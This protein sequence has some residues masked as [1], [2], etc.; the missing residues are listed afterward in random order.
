MACVEAPF[1]GAGQ[2]GGVLGREGEAKPLDD[3]AEEI[4]AGDV[5]EEAAVWDG[6][7]RLVL[8]EV[9][10]DAVVPRVPAASEDEDEDAGSEAT[11]LGDV[12]G[13]PGREAP[14]LEV[15]WAAKGCELLNFEGFLSSPQFPTQFQSSYLGTGDHLSS[16]S[17]RVNA[18]SDTI[19]R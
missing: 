16:R 18:F 10:E 4:G 2:R 14:A 13:P 6:I 11:V 9:A 8:A 19:D 3:L 1:C 17:R 7:A 15:T 5:V 12:A